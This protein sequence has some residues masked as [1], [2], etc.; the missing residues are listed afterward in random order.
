MNGIQVDTWIKLEAC[1]TTCTIV[2]GTAELQFGGRLDGL[3]ITATEAGLTALIA[4]G[5]EAV[6]QLRASRGHHA[7]H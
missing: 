2:D 7:H 6:E 4:S 5:T 3:T 1:E